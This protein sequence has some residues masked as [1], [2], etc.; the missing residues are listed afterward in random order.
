MIASYPV[1]TDDI[2]A[3]NQ[4]EITIYVVFEPCFRD[5]N[6]V[7]ICIANATRTSSIFGERDI[8]FESI[9]A[10]INEYAEPDFKGASRRMILQLK[11]LETP[12][13]STFHF[14]LTCVGQILLYQ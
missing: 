12:F 4:H 2:V 3:R 7:Q 13:N 10:D 6:E 8:T 9:N 5:A 14:L 1:S 11:P